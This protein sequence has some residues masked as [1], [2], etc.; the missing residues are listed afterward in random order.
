MLI[1]HNCEHGWVCESHPELPWEHDDANCGAPGS[2]C[3]QCDE[4]KTDNIFDEVC[5][6]RPFPKELL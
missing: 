6:S 1:E 5:C 4:W 3:D 2:V